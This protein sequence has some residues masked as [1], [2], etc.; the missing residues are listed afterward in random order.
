MEVENGYIW[1]VTTPPKFNIDPEKW[2]LEDYFSGAMLNFG[3]YKFD[4]K[5]S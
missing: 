4:S 5:E 3:G 1:K 2:W